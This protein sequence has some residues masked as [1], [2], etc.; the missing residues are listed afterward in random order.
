[1]YGRGRAAEFIRKSHLRFTRAAL[2]EM[3][4]KSMLNYCVLSLPSSNAK[5]GRSMLSGPLV[6][7]PISSI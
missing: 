7:V 5:R 3:Q 4:M 1:M 6:T 2:E